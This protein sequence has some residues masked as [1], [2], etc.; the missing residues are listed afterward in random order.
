[1]PI[2]PAGEWARG[3]VIVPPANVPALESAKRA[4]A[5]PGPWLPKLVEPRAGQAA[6]DDTQG[7]QPEKGGASDVHGPVKP[8]A[9]DLH[10]R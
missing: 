2:E 10:R 3:E 1:M 8:G 4:G 7:D 6:A 5:V 9:S